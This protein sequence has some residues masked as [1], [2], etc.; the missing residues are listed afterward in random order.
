M[1]KC[2]GKRF[3]RPPCPWI[4]KCVRFDRD[5][6]PDFPNIYAPIKHHGGITLQSGRVVE[7]ALTCDDFKE[8]NGEA[9]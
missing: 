5:F 2:T 7:G 6:I 3:N 8:K 9:K 1:K 4:E